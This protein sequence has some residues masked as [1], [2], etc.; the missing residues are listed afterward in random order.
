[1]RLN[2]L[3]ILV[4]GAV[5]CL[6]LVIG[7]GAGVA[8]TTATTASSSVKGKT[9]D[10]IAVNPTNSYVL[11]AVATAKQIAAKD[12][13][14]FTET[15]VTAGDPQDEVNAIQTAA[16]ADQYD[17]Y[18]IVP[19]N[20]TEDAPAIK[21]LVAT[22]KPV[23]GDSI[24]LGPNLCEEKPQVA[25]VAGA[26]LT[27]I[28]DVANQGFLPLTK[29][30]CAGLKPCNIGW[31]VGLVGFP[32]EEAFLAAVQKAAK[33][34][35]AHIYESAPTNYVISQA[36]AETQNLFV[37]HPNINVLWASAPQMYLGATKASD[38]PKN[39]RI[40]TDGGVQQQLTALKTGKPDVVGIVMG[41]GLPKTDTTNAMAELVKALQS[42][43]Y[44]N[45]GIDSI[46]AAGI[47]MIF[48]KANESQWAS[49]KPQWSAA[50]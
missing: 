29:E 37:A 13:L 34:I 50:G 41:N 40:A 45:V 9:V 4:A 10:F 27:P 7:A 24:A 49:F 1:M 15:G 19:Q 17:S 5:A 12:G 35:G 23:I 39:L 32:G 44:R 33:S 16:S 36:T 26:S 28:C 3:W 6:A 21:A 48:T 20:A 22:G 8:K 47:P 42:K 14:K 25:G 30:A 18:I 11:Q 31:L 46:K 38:L 2:K 43:S